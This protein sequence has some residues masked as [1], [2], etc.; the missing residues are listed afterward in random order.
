MEK[1]LIILLFLLTGCQNNRTYA[2][3]RYFN[4]DSISIDLKAVNDKILV[5]HVR[6]AFKLPH[7]LLYDEKKRSFLD[8]QLD[9]S[10]HYENTYLVREYDLL[11]DEE[12]SLQMTLEDLKS[13]R[14][15][16]E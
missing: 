3:S 15:L 4:D 14:Y 12:C 2:C 8:S 10:Y 9:D 5:F 11:P 1:K 7:T 13:R 6:E 16:C